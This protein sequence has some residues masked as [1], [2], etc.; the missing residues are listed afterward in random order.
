MDQNDQQKTPFKSELDLDNVSPEIK[1][2][3]YQVLME[4]EPFT[5][6]ETVVA[7]VAKDPLKLISSLEANG[8]D[9]DRTELKKMYRIS[10]SLTEEGTKLEEEALHEDIYSAIRL[11]KDKM[12]QVLNEI[13]DSVISNQD[14]TVQINTALGSGSVH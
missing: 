10:I 6:P 13:Q 2:Y 1:S 14:R 5:T 11:A 3:I 4:F 8:V 7:V 12:V 9:Y